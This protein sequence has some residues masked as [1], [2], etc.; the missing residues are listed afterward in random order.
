MCVPATSGPASVRVMGVFRG[1]VKKTFNFTMSAPLSVTE[2][3]SAG[4]IS[5]TSSDSCAYAFAASKTT[6]RST[7]TTLRMQAPLFHDERGAGA[8]FP[9]PLP[10]HGAAA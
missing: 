1:E 3:A 8:Q 6:N 9:H 10:L 4:E 5:F 7:L 2:I